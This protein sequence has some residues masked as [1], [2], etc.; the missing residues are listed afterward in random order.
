MKKLARVLLR[1]EEDITGKPITAEVIL[2]Y[3]VPFNIIRADIKPVGGEILIDIPKDSVD[4][5][6]KA[7]QERG[8][9]VSVEK[10][11]EVYA[12]KCIHCGACYSLCPSSVISFDD[13]YSIRFDEN[14][15]VA[16]GLC[17]DACPT[18][19]LKLL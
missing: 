5:I 8:V 2:E 17:I 11:L 3:G 12:E 14:K 1:F 6:V 18:Q 13:D 4:V 10:R 9:T 16:C 15:C 7:F 19:A